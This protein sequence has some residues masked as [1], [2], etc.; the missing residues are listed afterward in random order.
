[1]ST[2]ALAQAWPAHLQLAAIA[3][4]RGFETRNSRVQMCGFSVIGPRTTTHDHQIQF[5][6]LNLVRAYEIRPPRFQDATISAVCQQVRSASRLR[7][8]VLDVVYKI[9][10]GGM[11]VTAAGVEGA[12]RLGHVDARASAAGI[13]IVGKSV[14]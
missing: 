11:R 1:M 9:K 14:G 4:V 6:A 3:A 10:P 7:D 13:I 8:A 5:G 2:S 12:G